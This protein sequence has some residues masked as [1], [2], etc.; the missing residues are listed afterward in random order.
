MILG[1]QQAW[2]VQSANVSPLNTN[3][4]AA[5]MQKENKSQSPCSLSILCPH[6]HSQ[7]CSG[8]VY[9]F[10]K[11]FCPVG[12]VKVL[13]PGLKQG[14]STFPRVT[15]KNGQLAC[16]EA[17]ESK[18]SKTCP[19]GFWCPRWEQLPPLNPIGC[20]LGVILKALDPPRTMGSPEI[21]HSRCITHSQPALRV[22]R[23]SSKPH[24][25]F[26]AEKSII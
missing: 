24:G 6:L 17:R 9:H 4:A 11:H 13:T 14:R 20:S 12:P 3:Y 26:I 1:K 10:G 19:R 5:T 25:V 21:M 18:V 7:A 8:P 15:Y 2:L 16:G 22:H 23:L